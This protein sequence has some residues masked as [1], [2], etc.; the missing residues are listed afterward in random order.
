M[1]RAMIYEEM[2]SNKQ[3]ANSIF[4]MIGYVI[5]QQ[6]NFLIREKINK[7]EHY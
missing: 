6:K 3:R 7:N 4:V 2:A 1:K 5:C